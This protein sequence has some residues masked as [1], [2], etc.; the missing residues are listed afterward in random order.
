MQPERSNIG[1][2]TV[3]GA[4]IYSVNSTRLMSR[5][6]HQQYKKGNSFEPKR[7][8]SSAFLDFGYD[9]GKTDFYHVG[10]GYASLFIYCLFYIVSASG[11][12]IPDISREDDEIGYYFFMI[13]EYIATLCPDTYSNLTQLTVAVQILVFIICQNAL[14]FYL[15]RRY[16]NED[17]PPTALIDCWMS[18][19]RLVSPLF[20]CY[21]G[22]IASYGLVNLI[23]GR[24]IELGIMLSA[25]GI[26]ALACQLLLVVTNATLV[27][28][29][30]MMR[31]NDPIA[32]WYAYNYFELMAHGLII[33]MS[34]L[35]R[36]LNL[37]TNRVAAASVHFCVNTVCGIGCIIFLIQ[38]VPFIRPRANAFVIS[39][40][41]F[42]TLLGTSPLL[43]LKTSA[44]GYALIVYIILFLV[45]IYF[46]GLLM[47][48]RI[49]FALRK[50]YAW[51]YEWEKMM[52]EEEELGGM[53]VF[54]DL[55]DEKQEEPTVLD[56]G[57]TTPA[58]IEVAIRLGFLYHIDDAIA[59]RFLQSVYKDFPDTAVVLAMCQVLTALETDPTFLMT[60]CKSSEYQIRKCFGGGMFLRLVNDLRLEN[61]SQRNKPLM[62]SFAEAKKAT[63]ALG[64]DMANFWTAA[65]KGRTDMMLNFLPIVAVRMA[66]AENVYEK[67]VR[68]FQT[69]PIVLREIANFYHTSIGDH[70]K[71]VI[72]QSMYHRSKKVDLDVLTTTTTTNTLQIDDNVDKAFLTKMEPYM[73]AQ[74]AVMG[75]KSVTVRIFLATMIISFVG[76]LLIQLFILNIASSE[77]GNFEQNFTPVKTI[78]D[79]LYS[80]LRLLQLFRRRNLCEIDDIEPDH[81][82]STGPVLSTLLEFITVDAILPAIEKHLENT[83]SGSEMLLTY[84]KR[85]DRLKAMC[86]AKDYSK[87]S[88]ASSTKVTIYE[89][90]S[91]MNTA[92]SAMV[93]TS[94]WSTMQND[95]NM[96]FI[97]ENFEECYRAISVMITT[98]E[99]DLFRMTEN[100]KVICY[101]LL[102]I[103]WVFPA[104][105]LI[106]MT[107][108]A[109]SL[110]KKELRGICRIVCHFPKNELSSLR[111]FTGSS[112]VMKDGRQVKGE[113]T[114]GRDE[115]SNQNQDEINQKVVDSLATSRRTRVGMF[116]TFVTA[117]ALY[118]AYSG[119][120][121]TI[122]VV[123]FYVFAEQNIDLAVNT[124][125][126]YRVSA[127][128]PSSYI[129]FQE[130]FAKQPILGY[131]AKLLKEKAAYYV[132]RLRTN[133]NAFIFGDTEYNREP[134]VFMGK[135]I[136]N[137]F[138]LSKV[139]VDTANIYPPVNGFLH[140]VY[141]SESCDSEVRMMDDTARYL[142]NVS[143]T[144]VKYGFKDEF[145]YH[146][147]H[148]IFAHLDR[149]FQEGRVI[150]QDNTRNTLIFEKEIL[151]IV[152]TTMIVV[153]V[154][155]YFTIF[156]PGYVM[157]KKKILVI[158]N[159]ILLM[160]P[161]TILKT[162]SVM[163][164]ISGQSNQSARADIGQGQ[165]A[166]EFVD[167]IVNNSK[168]GL[169]I[170]DKNLNIT[171]FNHFTELVFRG[172][173]NLIGQNILSLLETY[174]MD[175][176]KA[177]QIK[178]L[179]EEV[180]K[181]LTG[182]NHSMA[183]EF[184]SSVLNA[185]GSNMY[186]SISL[187][188]HQEAGRDDIAAGAFSIVI[189]DRTTEYYQEALVADEKRKGDDLVA[190]LLPPVIVQRMNEGEKD[191]SFE[192]QQATVCFTSV[193]NWNTVIQD[194][195]AVE[196]V[197]F[198]NVLYS[199]YDKELKNFPEITKLK[200]IGH[201][202]MIAAGLFNEFNCADV[203][204]NYCLKCMNIV[205]QVIEE[206]GITFKISMGV[207][208]GGP[209]N[210]GILGH[211]RP[212]FDILGDVVNVSSRMN[213]SCIP[214]C[215]QIS[216]ST[217]DCVKF[218]SYQIR[219]RGEIT[220][221]GKGR[222]KTFFVS[223][224][225][226]STT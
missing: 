31:K 100:L 55:G 66:R 199:E 88:G 175:P 117:L 58:E 169:L 24:N 195:N 103:I 162:Q 65:L 141:F 163:R 224:A 25:V 149:F 154:I 194:M 213:S 137:H 95:E 46:T 85:S 220:V 36:I 67:N 152:F 18:V 49:R 143:D 16:Q 182:R 27:T 108:V 70:K 81:I 39:I 210:C 23:S 200:T 91:S 214:G 179:E 101:A 157:M 113:L 207:N 181:M 4:G 160:S 78:T 15:I 177:K 84:C 221:K 151:I 186:I 217:Y 222:M 64:D 52:D 128:G 72:F 156:L 126:L 90:F 37:S 82:E 74:E 62:D 193:C 130:L 138:I 111:R 94:D 190:S 17:Y 183:F 164:W 132:G 121:S 80:L 187:F 127:S 188:G 212:V 69:T 32:L 53:N 168:C 11:Y 44:L 131:S 134:A 173:E 167:H 8:L 116:N 51:H 75:V 119:V 6:E 198:L 79:L 150:L 161:T 5:L 201:I 26:P 176:K 76:Y 145:V 140:S 185:Q 146:F 73:A 225:T 45:S 102:G 56:Y 96:R 209:V 77:L 30:P 21:V 61:M 107:L 114:S 38:K 105:V 2:T 158:R 10:I 109:I 226:P 43:A 35:Q 178:R 29:T 215:I 219:E 204:L 20:S 115:T 110:T 54:C 93:N 165:V 139:V 148:L 155:C 125:R 86:E 203:M 89:M 98:L 97:F 184:K 159:L 22:Y 13:F 50:F 205:D 223:S 87:V 34:V 19:V 144:T 42:T 99:G 28:T 12:S 180:Q 123:V 59:S 83:R 60:V 133:F 33:G 129:F 3:S 92:M 189:A 63:K 71:C 153:M 47:T 206:T 135:D 57:F 218:L 7:T 68:N 41:F 136:Q 104:L 211:T 208:T 202:Y 172:T 191:I 216:E 118:I 171:Y 166:Q 112:S 124:F 1:P 122:G 192:V 197:K 147:E 120:I 106:P 174:L 14:T 48:C 9:I 170:M 40:F 142:L 196:V